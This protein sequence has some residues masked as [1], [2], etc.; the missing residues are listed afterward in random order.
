MAT[1]SSL[2][3]LDSS[4]S[5]SPVQN[6]NYDRFLRRQMWFTKN[7]SFMIRIFK[8]KRCLNSRYHNWAIC[9]YAHPGER[10]QRRDPYEYQYKRQM[11]RHSEDISK[12]PRG[13]RCKYAH[14]LY[15]YWLHPTRYRTRMC[16]RGL[17]CRRRVCFFAHSALQLRWVVRNPNYRGSGDVQ[18]FL[19]SRDS[20]L[21]CQAGETIFS[22]QRRLDDGS[23]IDQPSMMN[24]YIE[25][26]KKL[27][28]KFDY[29][30]Y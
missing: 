15:E 10:I 3:I 20:P 19:L 4:I 13:D 27:L 24:W 14:G 22:I 25:M 7:N 12:C 30:F 8:A 9:P 11:C 17:A 18:Y 16:N 21:H 23:G 29:E 2:F 1:Y 28:D 26:V 5:L 6:Y